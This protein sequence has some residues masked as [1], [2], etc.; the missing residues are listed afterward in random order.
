MKSLSF[1]Q[2]DKRT[3]SF[4]CCSFFVVGHHVTW[5]LYITI[6]YYLEAQHKI[7]KNKAQLQI[8][9]QTNKEKY[10]ADK[11]QRMLRLA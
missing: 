4:S 5:A 6:Y 11:L 9:Q 2:E 7:N 3:L 1:L 8:A 10:K